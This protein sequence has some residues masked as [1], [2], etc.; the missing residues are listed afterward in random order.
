V[1]SGLIFCGACNQPMTVKTTK[2][3]GKSYIN[4]ICSTHKRYGTCKNN[5]V[6]GKTVEQ[7]ALLN[8]RNHIAGLLSAEQLSS[9][10]LGLD[11]LKSRKKAVIEDMIGKALHSIQEYNDYL[12]KS[13]A[14]MLDGIITE[15]EYKIFRDDFRRQIEDAEKSIIYLRGEIDR[16]ADDQKTHELVEHFKTHGNITE[17]DRRA[18]VRLVHSI[19]VHNGK[20]DLEIILRYASGLEIMPEYAV[21]T[22]R[23]VG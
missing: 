7:F 21:A 11:E 13:C 16:L 8:I 20:E 1:F 5:N 9:G 2:K 22:E 19:I 14:H 6:S 18:A 15:S 3:N 10:G 17:I 23:A 12:V 4:Y